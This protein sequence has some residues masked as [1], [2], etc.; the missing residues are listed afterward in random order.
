[1]KVKNLR[2]ISNHAYH[3][4]KIPKDIAIGLIKNQSFGDLKGDNWW[5]KNLYT[6]S[7]E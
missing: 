6:Y 2:N 1:M 3:N 5:N 4:Y 7:W